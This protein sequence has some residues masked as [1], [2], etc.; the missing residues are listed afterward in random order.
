[1]QEREALGAKGKNWLFFGDRHF[2]TDFLYQ[3]EWQAYLKNGLLTRMNVA[4]SRDTEHKVYVQHKMLEHSKELFQ[5]IEEGAYLY[6]CGDMKSMWKDV[7]A[8]LLNIVVKEGGISAGQ[9]QEY[10]QKLKKERR[11]QADVY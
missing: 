8:T 6:V 2:T 11:Y 5:W 9:A 1:L 3:S 4:F 7:N 10:I